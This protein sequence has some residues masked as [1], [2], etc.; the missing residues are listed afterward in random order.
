MSFAFLQGRK[1]R[2]ELDPTPR[3]AL[4]DEKRAE[5]RRRQS[6]ADRQL[7]TDSASLEVG[8][9]QL[10]VYS[11]G[12]TRPQVETRARIRLLCSRHAR[13]NRSAS[14]PPPDRTSEKHSRT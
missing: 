1:E 4:R 9:V 10:Y 3:R 8:R 6:G 13:G 7:V 5:G 2:E 11:G 14:A 12:K